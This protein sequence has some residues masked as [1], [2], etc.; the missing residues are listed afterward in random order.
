VCDARGR[1]FSNRARSRPLWQF[2]I[3]WV[4]VVVVILALLRNLSS[5]LRWAAY[6]GL[7][8]DILSPLPLGT[9][10][11]ALVLAVTLA[12][13]GT[14]AIQ[15]DNMAVPTVAM[16]VV[17]LLYTGITGLVMTLIGLP[18][19]WERYPLTI[20]L[21]TALVNAM[22]ALPVYL[23]FERV[24]RRGRPDINFEL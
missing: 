21:P 10:L 17:S 7:A 2:R 3:D 23:L 19:I 6:G 5:G 12:T 14:E 22:V 16:I 9:H 20:M 24:Q 18:I 4:L 15:R 13:V 1:A 11:L 8:I